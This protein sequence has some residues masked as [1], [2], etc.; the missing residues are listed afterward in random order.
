MQ[1]PVLW[2]YFRN[3]EYLR[4][5]ETFYNGNL[6]ETI[7]CFYSWLL[8][9]HKSGEICKAPQTTKGSSKDSLSPASTMTKQLSV[10]CPGTIARVWFT[11]HMFGASTLRLLKKV[12]G[13]RSVN[14]MTSWCNIFPRHWGMNLWKHSS[15]RFRRWNWMPRPCSSGNDTAKSTWTCQIT[16]SSS[17][18]FPSCWGLVRQ[19]TPGLD[20]LRWTNKWR[21]SSLMP[22]PRT[23]LIFHAG[24]LFIPAPG[25]GL[26]HMLTSWTSW[27]Q[28]IVAW[29][30]CE[31]TLW[32][33]VGP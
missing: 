28:T 16:N 19:K 24:V 18:S 26:C 9:R 3:L 13:R 17:I 20:P 7:L 33:S 30:S 11:R 5:M 31:I 6:L 32:G 2:Q 1:L 8:K 21:C 27:S 10:S 23:A 22:H 12:L 15:P 14:Y 4:S 25:S 29:I